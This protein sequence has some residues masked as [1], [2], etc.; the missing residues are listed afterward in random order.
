MRNSSYGF[1]P[2]SLKLYRCLDHGLK[3]FKLF[4]CNPQTILVTFFQVDFSHFS[5]VI[6]FK[7]NR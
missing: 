4:G 2:I 1:M 7:V 5:G 3:M 6:T